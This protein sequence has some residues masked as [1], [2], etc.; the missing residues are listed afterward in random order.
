MLGGYEAL[1]VSPP[2]ARLF[3]FSDLV[4][5]VVVGFASGLIRI[6]SQIL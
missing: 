6:R 4:V 3:F 2:L 5:V 1:M